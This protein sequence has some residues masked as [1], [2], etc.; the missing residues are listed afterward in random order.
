MVVLPLTLEAVEVR[1]R[2]RTILGPID[3][4][5]DGDGITVVLGP[6]GAGKSTFL[7]SLHGVERLSKGRLVGAQD[8]AAREAQ[9]FVFQT[10]TMLRRSVA[11]NLAYPLQLQKRAKSE[12]TA[13]VSRWAARI[14]LADALD[15]PARRLSG[16]ERQKLA[17]AR[18]LIRNPQVL[19]LDEPCANLD[20]RAT[21]EIEMILKEAQASGT[22]IIL[23]THDLG[24]ARRLGNDVVFLLS[25]RI[26]ETALSDAFFDTPQTPEAQAFIRGDIVE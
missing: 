12:T 21:R 4:T 25:G 11:G 13:M 14:G 19:F 16:G 9:A 7:A 24:Q 5:L 1:R 2:G 18:A 15:V 6:N 3:Y 10:P 23:A 8:D 20:G 26:H 22:R 17:L